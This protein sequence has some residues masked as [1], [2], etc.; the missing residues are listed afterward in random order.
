MKYNKNIYLYNNYLST[1]SRHVTILGQ[2][3]QN[4]Y[5]KATLFLEKQI[6]CFDS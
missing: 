5:I 4:E 2:L 1:M 6:A 3:K